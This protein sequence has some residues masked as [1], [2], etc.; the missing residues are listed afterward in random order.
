MADEWQIDTPV[1]DVLIEI[2]W[3][4]MVDAEPGCGG[5]MAR[6]EIDCGRCGTELGSTNDPRRAY[7]IA[8]DGAAQG[9]NP[10]VTARGL[11][12]RVRFD[13]ANRDR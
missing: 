8:Q 3:Q 12:N 2:E 4:A 13:R 10:K 1:E 7:D 11:V 9:H 6:Y 5:L